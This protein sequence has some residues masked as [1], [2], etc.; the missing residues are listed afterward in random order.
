MQVDIVGMDDGSVGGGWIGS[1]WS[2]G[3]GAGAKAKRVGRIA[4][5][6]SEQRG[7]S[8]KP[9]QKARVPRRRSTLVAE[10]M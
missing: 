1:G 4:P 9:G 8:A 5:D 2:G 6:V 7:R 10:W 3:A